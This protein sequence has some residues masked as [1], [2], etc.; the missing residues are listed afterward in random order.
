[1]ILKYQNFIIS[2]NINIFNTNQLLT[3]IGIKNLAI[4]TCMSSTMCF[5][6]ILGDF[7]SFTL[8]QI[9]VLHFQQM[10]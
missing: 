3:I 8:E 4:T 9:F 6:G 10:L 5:K 1:M 2:H 7:F